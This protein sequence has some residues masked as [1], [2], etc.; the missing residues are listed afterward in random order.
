M[1]SGISVCA[2]HRRAKLITRAR[3]AQ[4]EDQGEKMGQQWLFFLLLLL[5]FLV[6]TKCVHAELE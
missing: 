2:S 5:F 4:I 6:Q 1:V 3:G